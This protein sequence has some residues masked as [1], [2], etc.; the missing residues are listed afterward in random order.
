MICFD[1]LSLKKIY[2]FFLKKKFP[3]P[4]GL[5]FNRFGPKLYCWVTEPKKPFHFTIGAVA[6]IS[7]SGVETTGEPFFLG[8]SNFEQQQWNPDPGGGSSS[9]TILLPPELWT[10]ATPS[11]PLTMCRD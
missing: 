6:T 11:G 8:E 4:D 1:L 7:R 10:D 5:G 3:L 2:I 9:T